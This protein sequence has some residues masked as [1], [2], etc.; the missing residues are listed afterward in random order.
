MR[1]QVFTVVLLFI[2]SGA[3][4][5]RIFDVKNFGAKGNATTDDAR[6]I[7]RAIDACSKAGGGIVLLPSPHT[8]LAGPFS[9]KSNVEF[10]VPAG[11]RLLA[12]PDEKV[13]TKS[14]FRKNPVE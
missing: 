10:R 14:A 11:A 8:F 2:A 4:A 6:A 1:I 12:N 7:Q 9:L 3:A 13:Y 5:Q